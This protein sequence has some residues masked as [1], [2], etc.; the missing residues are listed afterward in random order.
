LRHPLHQYDFK[1]VGIHGLEQASKPE[2]SGRRCAV[3][4]C[5]AMPSA[6]I[7]KLSAEWGR[8]LIVTSSVTQL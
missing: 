1:R 3:K 5:G 4:N 2:V 7:R 6:G 8:C